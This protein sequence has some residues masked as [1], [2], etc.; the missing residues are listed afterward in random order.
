VISDE[1]MP[2]MDGAELLSIIKV[3]YTETIR[4]M[5]TGYASPDAAMNA[6]N[7]GEVY[8]FFVKPWNDLELTMAI[9]SAIEKFDLEAENRR[10]LGMIRSQAVELKLM[11][12][13]HAGIT[14]LKKD[15]HGN[16]LFRD[17]SEEEVAELLAECEME[18]K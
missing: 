15:K 5:L 10:L 18:Y 14:R 8:R 3:R 17:F 1:R 11:E 9:K 7:R 12:R 13:Q 6:V 4:I 16:L 2:W